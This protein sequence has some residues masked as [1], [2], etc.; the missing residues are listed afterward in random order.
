M[1]TLLA[2][3]R[4][5]IKSF[6]PGKAVTEKNTTTIKFGERECVRLLAVG[7]RC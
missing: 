2:S 6:A 3:Q 1:E 4:V 5:I 7:N